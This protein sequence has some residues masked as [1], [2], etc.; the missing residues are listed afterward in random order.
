M[1]SSVSRKDK[2]INS[3][4]SKLEE[5]QNLASRHQKQVKE[6]QARLEEAEEEVEH[7]RQARAKAEKGKS[8]IVKEM[9]D[10]A[11]RLE[12]AGGA[13]NAQME[14]NK[15]REAELTKLNKKR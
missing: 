4:S 8:G 14:L 9:Q 5:E 12:E 1:E 13:T 2:E 7:E 15:K 6:L 3:L 11:D 10:L